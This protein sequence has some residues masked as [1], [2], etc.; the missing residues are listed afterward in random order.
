MFAK[1]SKFTIVAAVL[2]VAAKVIIQGNCS[3]FNP[4]LMK[5]G[6]VVETFTDIRI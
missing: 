1:L 4:P 6:D 3:I 5:N 2:E